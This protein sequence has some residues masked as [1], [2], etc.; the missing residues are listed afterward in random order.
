MAA[1]RRPFEHLNLRRNPFGDISDVAREADLVAGPLD[2]WVEWVR[3]RGHMLAFV[4]PRGC[5]KSTRLRASYERVASETDATVQL[6]GVVDDEPIEW[7]SADIL[8]VDE[9]QFVRRSEWRTLERS[10]PDSL[11]VASH[12][13]LSGVARRFDFQMKT[14]DCGGADVSRVRQMV[15]ARFD[16]MR[17]DD[18]PIPTVTD[19]GCEWLV[20]EYGSDLR[21]SVS[22][23]YEVVQRLERVRSIRVDDLESTDAPTP[24]HIEPHPR[25]VSSGW[26]ERLWRF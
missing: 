22:H 2:A 16:A 11:V 6:T 13:E 4:G 17:R 25:D 14:I 19:D 18:G 8:M 23:L 7:P 21:A 3:A 20:A 24:D 1:D 9:A 15:R 5:G 26:L 12:E 10:P